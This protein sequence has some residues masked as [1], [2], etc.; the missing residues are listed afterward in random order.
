MDIGEYIDGIVLD[1]VAKT[2]DYVAS[3]NELRAGIQRLE[4]NVEDL[5]AMFSEAHS[6]AD[7]FDETFPKM[8]AASAEAV[9]RVRAVSGQADG[10]DREIAAIGRDMNEVMGS[11]EDMNEARLKADAESRSK[12]SFLAR[13]SHEIRTPMNTIIGM[14]ELAE[15][16]WGRPDGLEYMRD[17]KEAGANLLSIIN[18][19]LDYSRMESGTMKIAHECYSTASLLKDVVAIVRVRLGEKPIRFEMDVDEAIPAFMTGDEV[20][21]RQVLLQLL[22]N[23]IKFTERGFVKLAVRFEYAGMKEIRLVL[24]VSDSGVGIRNEELEDVFSGFSKLDGACH[25]YVEGIGLGLTIARH[26]CRALGGDIVATSEYGHGSTFTVTLRQGIEDDRRLGPL[27]AVLSTDAGTRFRAPDFRVLVVD[28]MATNLK[29]ME[30]LLAPYDLRVSTCASGEKAVE[31]VREGAFDLVFMDHMMPGMDGVEAVAAMRA[32][33]LVGLP[34]VALTANA[35]YGMKEM[36]L[37]NGFDDFLS[38]PIEISK[39]DAVLK[40]WIPV[41]KHRNVLKKEEKAPDSAK[42]TET[43]LPEIAG[44]DAAAGLARIGGSPR[45]YLELLEMFRRDAAAV[46]PSLEK[47]PDET[48]LRAFT[49]EVHALKSALANIG[50]NDLSHTAARLEKAG[51]EADACI[52]RDTLPAFREEL[53]TLTAQIA[54]F[55]AP[56]HGTNGE[57]G[58]SPVVKDALV[59]LHEALEA[60]DIGAVDAALTQA[61]ALS[62]T[63][64]AAI[65]ELADL[66]L[67]ADFEKAAD[68]LLGLLNRDAS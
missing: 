39:L 53:D 48:S 28:D 41:D 9:R 51:R 43:A 62:P 47:E 32:L 35:V 56:P 10:L 18:E 1:L 11:V 49:T 58:V 23:A 6:P 8:A 37:E 63:G 59:R 40:K 24:A 33:G 13:M 26:I 67:I 66:I 4:A 16:A 34:I 38:K 21:V 50:A 55:S 57:E 54:E 52:I 14:S 7:S 29:V 30:G 12:S 20:R 61:Q 3:I 22:A 15:R 46:F 27:D 60:K 68:K 31:L 45:R 17:I 65:S 36:F 25:E 2:I 19:I 44:L 64:D 42:R 5:H